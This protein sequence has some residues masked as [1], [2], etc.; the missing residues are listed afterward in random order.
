[1]TATANSKAEIW[2][3]PAKQARSRNTRDR[4][5]A[6]GLRLLLST[7][8]D[9]LKIADIAADAKCSVGS[10][11]WRFESKDTY[12][13]A[14]IEVFQHR[15]LQSALAMY[16]GASAQ[17]IVYR[18][19]QRERA[20]AEE[21]GNLWR[22]AILRGAND[23]GFWAEVRQRGEVAIGQFL[24]WQAVQ[25]GRPLSEEQE[26]HIRFAFRMVRS[27]INNYVLSDWKPGAQVP[28]A[29]LEQLERAFRR[30][31]DID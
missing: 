10:F 14:L 19:L 29:L 16:E 27:T 1:M 4:L 3:L 17:T 30:I 15:R 2:S 25:F 24:G 7:D 22:A 11:Y 31:A 23:P 5:I 6:S 9:E 20:L 21:F 12:F 18:L 28:P 26:M 13:R 8:F